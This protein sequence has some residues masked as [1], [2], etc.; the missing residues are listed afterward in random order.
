[1]TVSV[2]PAGYSDRRGTPDLVRRRAEA[3]PAVPG[4]PVAALAAPAAES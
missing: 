2:S 4:R 1:V 3:Q